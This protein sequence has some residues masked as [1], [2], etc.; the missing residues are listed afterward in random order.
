MLPFLPG[1]S[2]GTGHPRPGAPG[3]HRA[4]P[5]RAL[6]IFPSYDER[7]LPPVTGRSQCT[8]PRRRALP[9]GWV[10]YLLFLSK[11]PLSR[12][13]LVTSASVTTGARRDRA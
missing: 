3:R 1:R 12:T 5:G 7:A 11:R 8:K 10:R 9:I 13:A 4:Y 6:S 2:R